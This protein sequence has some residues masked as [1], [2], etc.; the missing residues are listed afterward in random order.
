MWETDAFMT[1][2]E[3][4]RIGFLLY[5]GWAL[6]ELTWEVLWGVGQGVGRS[7]KRLRAER[8]AGR[9]GGLRYK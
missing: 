1:S 4:I 2:F 5:T 6:A 7:V 8:R 9:E 3:I